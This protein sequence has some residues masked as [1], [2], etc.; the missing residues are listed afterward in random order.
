MTV[1]S[2][3]NS[4]LKYKEI[5]VDENETKKWIRSRLY[6]YK[7]GLSL[8]LSPTQENVTSL[9]NTYFSKS[10]YQCPGKSGK[11]KRN[12]TTCLKKNCIW[13]HHDS[14]KQ[15]REGWIFDHWHEQTNTKKRLDYA[16]SA[17]LFTESVIVDESD[18][19]DNL[20]QI[21]VN[22]G[23]DDKRKGN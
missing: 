16:L 8:N 20:N 22:V 3:L 5:Q 19:I 11:M 18:F 1:L 9:Y 23:I 14:F 7:K 2:T 6:N 12:P 4:V 13:I 17:M 10:Y 21:K 15:E